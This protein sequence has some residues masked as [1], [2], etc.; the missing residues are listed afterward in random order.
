MSGLIKFVQKGK[1]ELRNLQKVLSTE[2][3]SVIGGPVVQIGE[4][5]VQLAEKI[6]EGS[7]SLIRSIYLFHDLSYFQTGGFAFVF[8]GKEV[9][10]LEI[11]AVKRIISSDRSENKRLKEEI[12][13]MVRTNS[14]HKHRAMKELS[15][16]SLPFCAP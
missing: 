8:L 16:L 10:T 5:K 3:S 11:F 15:S 6:A 14:P 2:F 12:E 1:D 7:V 9:N 4:Y 13:T